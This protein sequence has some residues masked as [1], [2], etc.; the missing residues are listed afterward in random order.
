MLL[1]LG[2]RD[3]ELLGAQRLER[4]RARRA[5]RMPPSSIV[6][7]ATMGL[8]CASAATHALGRARHRR[9]SATHQDGEA[10]TTGGVAGATSVGSSRARARCSAPRARHAAHA[11]RD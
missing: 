4:Q 11:P 2:L 6:L 1:E 10:V 7:F 3:G 5:V 9:V 8:T